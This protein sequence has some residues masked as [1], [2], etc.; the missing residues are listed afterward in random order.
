[1]NI[2]II[3]S[4]SGGLDSTCLLMW[5]L[6]KGHPVTAVSFKYGQNHSIELKRAAK[7]VKLLQKWGFPVDHR[8]V[9]LTSAFALSTSALHGGVIP[10]GESYNE[11]NMK[12]TVV[13]NR[14]VI[15]SSIIYGMA[16]G[17]AK[18]NDSMVIIAQG[19]HN[20]DHD[21]YP[22]CRPESVEMAKKLYA[23]SNWGSEWVE[24][25]TPFV[26]F[27]KGE[28]LKSGLEAMKFAGF[29]PYRIRQV[30]ANTISCYCPD[31][32]G[33]PCGQCGTCKERAEA[34]TFNGIE[35]PSL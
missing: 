15:F 4:Y 29:K 18:R 3:L 23:I 35:D 21:L 1:M 25:E 16:L 33:K 10:K 27:S 31:E 13:E 26:N 5:Y 7:N 28:V 6:S 30:L 11:S 20:G 24:F 9:D 12:D 14:N 32:N 34:F 2:P 8:I 19:V 17:V 22:D